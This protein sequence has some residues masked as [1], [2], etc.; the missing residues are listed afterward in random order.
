MFHLLTLTCLIVV[1]VMVTILCEGKLLRSYVPLQKLFE[2]E[3]E[4]PDCAL[5]HLYNH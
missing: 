5:G 2:E 1:V 4:P 3:L